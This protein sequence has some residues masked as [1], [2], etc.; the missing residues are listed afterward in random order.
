SDVRGLRAVRAVVTDHNLRTGTASAQARARGSLTGLMRQLSSAGRTPL[1]IDLLLD[2]TVTIPESVLRELE[3][4]AGALL[5][6]TRHPSGLPAWR[7]YHRAFCDRYGICALVPVSDVVNPDVGLGYPAGYPG[8]V[9]PAPADGLTGRDRQ[10]LALAWEAV[11][12]RDREV[13]L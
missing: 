13:V 4:A 10:L 3:R 6:L 8:S 9:Q 7:E 12:R 5:R 1:A 11:G 2:R